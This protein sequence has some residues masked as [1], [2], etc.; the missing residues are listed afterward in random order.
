MMD[1][2]ALHGRNDDPLNVS[3]RVAR[4]VHGRVPA[5]LRVILVAMLGASPDVVEMLSVRIDKLDGCAVAIDIDDS[6][7]WTSCLDTAEEYALFLA[8]HAEVHV[9]SGRDVIEEYRVPFGEPLGHGL[10]PVTGFVRQVRTGVPRKAISQVDRVVT[11]ETEANH[12][13]PIIRDLEEFNTDLKKEK[14][15]WLE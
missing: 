7:Q 5:V 6:P 1:R 3:A 9:P 13:A 4:V 11:S 14:R 8:I 15:D 12:A 2:N 10:R